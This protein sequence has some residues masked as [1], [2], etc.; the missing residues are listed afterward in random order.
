MQN[1][2]FI[3]AFLIEYVGFSFFFFLLRSIS[4]KAGKKHRFSTKI[5]S[6]AQFFFEKHADMCL[7]SAHLMCTYVEAYERIHVLKHTVIILLREA[8]R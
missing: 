8:W 7:K 1:V 3:S 5:C 6:A 2:N 4:C